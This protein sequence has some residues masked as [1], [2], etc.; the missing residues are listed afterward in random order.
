MASPECPPFQFCGCGPR[1]NLI[2]EAPPAVAPVVM[3]GCLGLAMEPLSQTLAAPHSNQR[4]PRVAAPHL[5]T[6]LAAFWL[7]PPDNCTCRFL[8]GRRRF[9][10]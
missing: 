9:S 6:A 4:P 8:C 1:G 2:Q 10:Q 7:P 5:T 3:T